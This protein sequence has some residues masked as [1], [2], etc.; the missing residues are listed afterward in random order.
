MSDWIKE[1]NL[2]NKRREAGEE[3]KAYWAATHLNHAYTV[4]WRSHRYILIQENTLVYVGYITTV[5]KI[6]E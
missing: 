3:N 2:G 4:E 5:Y 1:I 6:K